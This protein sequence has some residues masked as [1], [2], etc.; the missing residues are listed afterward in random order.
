MLASEA[1]LL[2]VGRL[3]F[4]PWPGESMPPGQKL[5]GWYN[6][7]CCVCDLER[8]KPKI[9][10]VSIGRSVS[11]ES[12]NGEVQSSSDPQTTTPKDKHKTKTLFFF[13]YSGHYF[14][15]H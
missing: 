2:C 5:P 12:V 4:T 6:A 1:A 10:D 15:R 3:V 7:V 8:V 11:L 13:F 9:G 14:S